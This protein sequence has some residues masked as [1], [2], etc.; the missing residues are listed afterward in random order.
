MRKGLLDNWGYHN[1][2]SNANYAKNVR[3]TVA[4]AKAAGLTCGGIN[5]ESGIVGADASLIA[6]KAL[7]TR[8]TGSDGYVS[9]SFRKTVNDPSDVSDYAFFDEYL[10]P[11]EAVLTFGTVI[12]FLGNAD[13]IG[14]RSEK[15]NIIMDEYKTADGT[16]L[17]CYSFGETKRIKIQPTRRLTVFL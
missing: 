16:I 10:Q 6:R 13:Y 11:G 4:L 9:F 8:S 15:K 14:N 2:D 12:R 5:S 3:A 7:F 1:H 17:A